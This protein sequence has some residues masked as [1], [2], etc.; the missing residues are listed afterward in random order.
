MVAERPRRARMTQTSCSSTPHRPVLCAAA[1]GEQAGPHKL[2]AVPVIKQQHSQGDSPWPLDSQ[3]QEQQFKEVLA[4]VQQ[5]PYLELQ[6]L[7][8]DQPEHRAFTASFLFWLSAQEKKADG[9]H[10]Q[11]R[12][13]CTAALSC[14]QAPCW[15]QC[16]LLDS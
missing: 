1:G 10:K 15:L 6:H 11:V 12:C 16:L 5:L 7:I 9:Q 2:E 8:D 4:Q 3:Q 13:V 14:E